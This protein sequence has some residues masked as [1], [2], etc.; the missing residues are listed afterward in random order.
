M[1]EQRKGGGDVKSGWMCVHIDWL[2]NFKAA[3]EQHSRFSICWENKL[4]KRPI[5]NKL[6]VFVCVYMVHIDEKLLLRRMDISPKK[7]LKNK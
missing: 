5:K 4:S 1:R 7:F 6:T 2:Y 3:G